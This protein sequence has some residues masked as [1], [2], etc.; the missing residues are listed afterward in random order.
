MSCKIV[1]CV[2]SKAAMQLTGFPNTIHTVYTWSKHSDSRVPNYVNNSLNI[3]FN[4]LNQK[5]PLF[6]KVPSK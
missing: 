3:S 5:Q 4:V 6:P 1:S 2:E